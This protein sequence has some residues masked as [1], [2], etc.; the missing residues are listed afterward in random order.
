MYQLT[1][2][3][4]LFNNELK[5]LNNAVKSVLQSNLKTKLFLIDNSPNDNLKY[6]LKE[7]ISTSKVEYIFNNKNIGYGKAH[8]IALKK[9]I[10]TAPYH[11]VLNPDVEFK[12][13]V[14]E[15]IC[16][17]MQKNLSVG[18][19][20]PQVLNTDGTIQK[21]C[22]LLPTPLNLI[23][24]RFF[25]GWKWA[26]NI[27]ETY[28]LKG[29]NYDHCINLPNLSGC[30]MFLRTEVLKKVGLFD[31]RYFMYMED[32]DLTRRVHTISETLF[33]P[34]VSIYHGYEK[35]SY[36]NPVVFKYHLNSAVRYFN[37]WGWFFDKPRRL[38]NKETLHLIKANHVKVRVN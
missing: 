1:C 34:D 3:I 5:T 29:F 13:G 20:Q 27:D 38:M 19:L 24:R 16:S 22:K 32:M 2:S 35:A 9:T 26:E 37:K 25:S 6:H 21:L 14:L 15:N 4:V 28:H 23:G 11:L 33:Y 10:E 17:F 8:N 36:S 18:Q 30:F 12:A 31:P 7:F